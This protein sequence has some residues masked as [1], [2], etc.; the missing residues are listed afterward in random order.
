MTLTGHTG[1][2]RA[3]AFSPDGG[4]VA[5]GGVDR[6]V[7]VWDAGTGRQ[8]LLLRHPEDVSATGYSP[9]G[10]RIVTA[11]DDRTVRVWDAS[12]GREVLALPRGVPVGIARFHPRNGTRLL[13]GGGGERVV[14]VWDVGANAEVLALRHPAGVTAAAFSP[15]GG[16]IVTGGSDGMLRVWDATTGDEILPIAGSPSGVASVSFSPDGARLLA[17]R[18]GSTARTAR[19]VSVWLFGT[20][21]PIRRGEPGVLIWDSTPLNQSSPRRGSVPG[22]E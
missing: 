11:C 22:A 2:L 1:Q 5:T 6:T 15:D 3:L 19:A 10:A 4:R 14:S 12:T 7:R 13:I 21:L 18:P 8:H 16:R 20:R 9:D 17:S